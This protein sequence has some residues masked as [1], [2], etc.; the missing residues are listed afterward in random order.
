MGSGTHCRAIADASKRLG[1]CMQ[2]APGHMSS[3][4]ATSSP[5]PTAASLAVLV[6]ERL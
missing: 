2:V 6:A 4:V 3:R 5:L 1:A